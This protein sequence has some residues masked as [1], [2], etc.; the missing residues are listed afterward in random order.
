V[1]AATLTI[2]FI[3]FMAGGARAVRSMTFDGQPDQNQ[4]NVEITY[5]TDGIQFVAIQTNLSTDGPGAHFSLQLTAANPP[6]SLSLPLPIVQG[7]GSIT[8]TGTLAVPFSSPQ[9]PGTPVQITVERWDHGVNSPVETGNDAPNVESDSGT[10]D[11]ID[12]CPFLPTATATDAASATSTATSTL[13]PTST[14]VASDTPTMLIPSATSTFLPTTT[15]IPVASATATSP[16][17]N[18]PTITSLRLASATST[19]VP[20]LPAIATATATSPPVFTARA[21]VQPTLI[22]GVSVPLADPALPRLLAIQATSDLRA[23]GGHGQFGETLKLFVPAH[24]GAMANVSSP[25]ALSPANLAARLSLVNSQPDHAGLGYIYALTATD[26]QGRPVARIDGAHPLLIQLGYDPA[27]LGGM[28]P[29]T[30]AIAVVDPSRL[31]WKSLPTSVDTF[32]HLLTA[33]TT[34]LSFFQVQGVSQNPAQRTAAQANLALLAASGV[35]HVSLLST[36]H[37]AVGGVPLDLLLPTGRQHAPVSLAVTGAP[38]ARLTVAFTLAGATIVQTLRLDAQGYATTSFAPLQPR[39]S[40]QTLQVAV[41]VSLGA[42][43]YSITRSISLQPGQ[44]GD[45]LP[46]GAPPLWATLASSRVRAA[47]THP[48]V[49]VQTAAGLVVQAVLEQG[50]RPLAGLQA[51]SGTAGRQG[52]AQCRLPLIPRALLLA[53]GRGEPKTVT[54]QVLVSVSRRGQSS[55]QTL[56]LTVSL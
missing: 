24:A 8:V 31:T 23:G 18:T 4:W 1:I 26:T 46:S 33:I 56:P 48:L 49:Q 38:G 16:P 47:V 9:L 22:V 19:A 28:N 6:V 7:D 44:T 50:G 12:D 40:P 17:T 2:I 10:V 43:R 11:P 35:P 36:S 20:I 42:S 30:L 53:D 32:H 29:A 13:T 21:T 27:S 14:L 5:C 51:A 34:S 39:K 54:L 41:S 3:L 52:L 45:P 37:P 25:G 55:Q 15:P